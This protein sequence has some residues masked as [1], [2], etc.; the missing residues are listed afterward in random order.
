[1]QFA[2]VDRHSLPKEAK[3][4]GE[5]E[6]EETSFHPNQESLANVI[7]QRIV[8]IIDG[9][10]HSKYTLRPLI[11]NA[12]DRSKCY[13]R[14]EFVIYTAISNMLESQTAKRVADRQMEV[15][16]RE[17]YKKTKREI[18]KEAESKVKKYRPETI[19]THKKLMKRVEDPENERT[20][21]LIV[22]DEAH[23]AV[24]KTEDEKKG[25]GEKHT[26]ERAND[27]LVNYW[28]DEEHPNVIVLQ[29]RKYSCQIC[30]WVE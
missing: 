27:T 14:F 29:V 7:I 18:R 13:N 11:E 4:V 16:P 28:K 21:F 2:E 8:Q 17:T 20:L 23:V 25:D 5:T 15:F 3:R 6:E 9:N 12:S 24:T 22:A 1:M 26:N 10:Q 30:F 19:S